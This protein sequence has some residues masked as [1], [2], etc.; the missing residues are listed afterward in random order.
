[1]DSVKLVDMIY[2]FVL[3]TLLYFIIGTALY[4]TFKVCFDFYNE[5][6]R[7]RVALMILNANQDYYYESLK[8]R[9]TELYKNQASLLNDIESRPES[10]EIT[11][12][13]FHG[14]INNVKRRSSYEYLKSVSVYLFQ[15]V[16][17]NT[18]G[19]HGF[20]GS[21]TVVADKDGYF[22]LLTNKHVCNKDN[23]D[24]CYVIMGNK[25]EDWYKLEFVKQTESEYDLALWRTNIRLKDK[26]A[27]K[28]IS[29][30]NPQ[31]KVF[32][33]GQ[34]LSNKYIYTEGTMAGYEDTSVLFNMPCAPG[35][36]G[37]GI[38]DARRNLVAVLYAGNLV[39][40]EGIPDGR[41]MDTSKAIA[42]N[43]DIVRAFLKD[44][45]DVRF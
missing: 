37:S 25:R 33:V 17:E 31:Q 27:I 44:I 18:E 35:C 13:D 5:V 40:I 29:V 34:Y 12:K 4:F 11:N 21:G 36:S 3:Y 16:E 23:I 45:L 26:R 24:N 8:D 6:K 39:K 41:S 2:R 14:Q 7:Q 10:Q 32:S 30:A 42:I 15:L 22:Y 19:R 9:L 38:F 1:M 20:V 43:G 28:G